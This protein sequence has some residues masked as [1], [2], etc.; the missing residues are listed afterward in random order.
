MRHSLREL[1]AVNG[2]TILVSETL[3]DSKAL[4]LTP[5]ADTVYAVNWIDLTDGPVVIE[6][7]PEAL[8]MR[9]ISSSLPRARGMRL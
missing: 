4:W 8:G 6:S 5:N 2:K 3:L 1:G 7:P 9:A